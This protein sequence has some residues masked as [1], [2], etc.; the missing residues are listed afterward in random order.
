[1]PMLCS[2]RY[3]DGPVPVPGAGLPLNRSE[4]VSAW[5]SGA[6]NHHKNSL[7]AFGCGAVSGTM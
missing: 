7:P 6:M 1:M 3:F 4:S 5:P 2:C